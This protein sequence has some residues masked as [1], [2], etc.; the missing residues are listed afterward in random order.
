MISMIS[1]IMCLKEKKLYNYKIVKII[2]YFYYILE[3]WF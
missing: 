2:F 3:G 1:A